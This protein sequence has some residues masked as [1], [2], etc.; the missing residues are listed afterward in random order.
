MLATFLAVGCS[1]CLHIEGPDPPVIL[2]RNG[3][4][5]WV[6]LPYRGVS[7]DRR[8]RFGFKVNDLTRTIIACPGG[9]D[10]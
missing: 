4:L 6:M 5:R 8:D 2:V 10:L 7:S 9:V 1:V 3:K